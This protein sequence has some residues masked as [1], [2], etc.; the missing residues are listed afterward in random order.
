MFTKM[1]GLDAPMEY[2]GILVCTE[3]DDCEEFVPNYFR[4]ELCKR[5]GHL[6]E[7]HVPLDQI[8]KK[9]RGKL[10]HDKATKINKAEV[11][12]RKAEIAERIK[13]E[14]EVAKRRAKEE[15]ERRVYRRMYDAMRTKDFEEVLAA[16]E[17]E[18]TD[19]DFEDHYGNTPM[20]LA[21]QLGMHRWIQRLL[22]LGCD[23]SAINCRSPAI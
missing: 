9:K 12:K 5:C 2:L 7:M 20:I 14:K 21:S 22:K 10:G 18:G 6:Q 4:R 23:R 1:M 3:C 8:P 11:A 15:E 16:I 17:V 13:R 19:P